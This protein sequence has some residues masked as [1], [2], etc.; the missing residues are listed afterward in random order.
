MCSS[1]RYKS[2]IIHVG[3]HLITYSKKGTD[4][5]PFGNGNFHNARVEKLD[6]LYKNFDRC[7]IECTE[8]FEKLALFF[9]PGFEIMRL[10]AVED[11][12]NVLILTK[13]SL[14]TVVQPYHGRT[15]IVLADPRMF[16]QTGRI[17]EMPASSLKLVV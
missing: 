6:T 14:N 10:A 2:R 15:A 4:Y 12:S 5:K 9:T 7:Y 13:S 1:I 8:F 16:V 3:A 17:L 11:E